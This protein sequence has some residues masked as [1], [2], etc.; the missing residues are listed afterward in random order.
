MRPRA[1]GTAHGPFDI[2][3]NPRFDKRLDGLINDLATIALQIQEPLQEARDLLEE[4]QSHIEA[5]TE[6]T[7]VRKELGE[8]RSNPVEV[9][10]ATIWLGSL[11]VLAEASN[12]RGVM[13]SLETV[14]EVIDAI[15]YGLQG[16]EVGHPEE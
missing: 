12:P 9:D 5:E 16:K 13:R 6:R 8:L 1:I 15:K 4:L 2:K 7:Q 10:G 3:L 14:N 11:A